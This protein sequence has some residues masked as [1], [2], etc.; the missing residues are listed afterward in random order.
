MSIELKQ[1][2]NDIQAPSLYN[3]KGTG[4]IIAK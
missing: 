2:I 3:L 4:G 1:L